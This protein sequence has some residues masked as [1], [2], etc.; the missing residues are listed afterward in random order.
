MS[1]GRMAWSWSLLSLAAGDGGRLD[2]DEDVFL[3]FEA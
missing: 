1:E 2:L 3:R